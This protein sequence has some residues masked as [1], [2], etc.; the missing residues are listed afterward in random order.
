MTD[1]QLKRAKDILQR[2]YDLWNKTDFRGLGQLMLRE[3]RPFLT[4]Q[5]IVPPDEPVALS[6]ELKGVLRMI[7]EH[8][9]ID[10][11]V[12]GVEPTT[13]LRRAG[14]V[15]RVPHPTV[16][17]RG[18]PADAVQSTEAGRAALLRS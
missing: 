9:P 11:R 2:G 10:E 5:H 15:Q 14:F 16:K 8:E 7:V 1:E 17:V 13:K 4:G 3:V 18:V 12:V 6:P